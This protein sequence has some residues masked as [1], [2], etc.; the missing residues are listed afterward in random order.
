MR[1]IILAAG[2][3][4]RLGG[5]ADDNPKCL[6]R[7]GGLTLLERQIQGLA[8]A[9]VDEICIVVGCRANRVRRLLGG[10]V[11]YVE[12][13][14]FAQTNSLYSLWLARPLLLDGFVVLNCDVLFHPQMLTDL[15]T[16]R[17]ENAAVVD[18]RD[19]NMVFGDEEMKVKVRRGRVVDFSK[20]L[21][22]EDA[23]AENVGMLKF[24][25]DGA[26]ALVA[27]LDRLVAEGG[28]REWAPRAFADFARE[29][30]LFAVGTRG[31]P[32]VEIDFPE[33]YER[34]RS[35]ILPAIEALPG[36]YSRAERFGTFQ[37]TVAAAAGTS[38]GGWPLLVG[39][40]GV[41]SAPDTPTSG[42]K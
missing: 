9:G 23:D 30:P 39:S 41:A 34:A 16:A 20:Q 42:A 26:S 15:V 12:N 14:R 5:V 18:Y 25:R 13:A 38:A 29:Q 11:H 1:G 36:G 35:E 10:S 17:C 7:V 40:D 21:P 31:Y 28:V 4:S 8:G 24:G 3:G 32:W 19:E 6:L 22:L 27:H 33:D 2:R 37:P